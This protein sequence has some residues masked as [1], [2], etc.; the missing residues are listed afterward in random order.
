MS[1]A[2]FACGFH[3]LYVTNCAAEALQIIGVPASCT[4]TNA[5]FQYSGGTSYMLDIQ[6][7]YNISFL[8]SYIENSNAPLAPIGIGGAAK[9]INF[10]GVFHNLVNGTPNVPIITTS[11][12][13]AKVAGIVHA[14]G[15]MA[16]FLQLTGTLPLATLSEAY[17]IAG[18]VA[19]PFD[20]QSTRKA[21]LFFDGGGSSMGP[22]TLRGLVSQR[23]SGMA[24]Q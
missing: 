4:F 7:G 2:A 13:Q 22:L 21:G 19:T 16:S 6:G 10:L 24:A 3:G 11:A 18:T 20:D 15:V 9:G 8:G 12:K 17:V 5:V 23:P 14:G 1:D